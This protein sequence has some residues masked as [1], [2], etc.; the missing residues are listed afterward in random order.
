MRLSWLG[1][2]SAAA[3]LG[4]VGAGPALSCV[5]NELMLPLAGKVSAY[6]SP[7]DKGGNAVPSIKRGQPLG[8][9]CTDIGREGA[10]VRVV[11]QFTQAMDESPTGFG[12]VL[13]TEQTITP[14]TV[15]VLVPDMP[16]L[17]NHT[18]NVK[19]FVTDPTGT[20]SCDAGRVKIV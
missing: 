13:A 1:Y 16:D 7:N 5:P 14:G 6:T 12:A 3:I 10:D 4:M 18:V 17:A 20:H 8:I 2:I 15:H 9:A 19:V 11:L